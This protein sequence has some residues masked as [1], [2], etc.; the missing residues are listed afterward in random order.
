[1]G[2]S[3]RGSKGSALGNVQSD[4]GNTDPAQGKCSAWGLVGIP[5]LRG[6]EPAGG[7]LAPPQRNTS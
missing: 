2:R 7:V 4:E 3:G 5:R 6:P 1:M